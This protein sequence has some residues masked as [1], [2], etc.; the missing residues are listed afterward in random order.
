MGSG[1]R[2]AFD[3]IGAGA[4]AARMRDGRVRRVMRRVVGLCIS[5]C[6]CD[7]RLGSGL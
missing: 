6:V 5:F 2:I 4:G 3:G 7:G 1:A